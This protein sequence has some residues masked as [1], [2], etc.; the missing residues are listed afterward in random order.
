M[1]EWKL[2]RR[3]AGLALVEV[4][5]RDQNRYRMLTSVRS[6]LGEHETDNTWTKIPALV[7]AVE[8]LETVIAQVSEQ[9]EAT[10]TPSGASAGKATALETL[11][12]STHEIASAL[13]ACATA[14][15]NE[16][17]AAEVDFSLTALAKGREADVVARCSKILS[18]ATDNLDNLGD[19]NVTQAKLTALGKKIDAFKKAQTKPR[20]GVA[21][22]AAANKALPRLFSRRATF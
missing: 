16:E 22:K 15:G 18:L 4:N 5:V 14:S 6:T 12:I 9:L 13:H 17:L 10:A 20:Q 21:K 2:F 7:A 1:D 3:L 8:E 19:Y 11:V